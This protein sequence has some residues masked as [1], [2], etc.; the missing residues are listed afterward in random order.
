MAAVE[1]QQ[2]SAQRDDAENRNRRNKRTIESSWKSGQGIDSGTIHKPKK[3]NES[4]PDSRQPNN[5]FVTP[6]FFALRSNG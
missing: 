5:D 1:Q 4:R 3:A 2:G 6:T